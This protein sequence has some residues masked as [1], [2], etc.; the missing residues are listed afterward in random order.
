MVII[1]LPAYDEEQTLPLVLEAI[2]EDFARP[3]VHARNLFHSFV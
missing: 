1:T 2:R 3:T